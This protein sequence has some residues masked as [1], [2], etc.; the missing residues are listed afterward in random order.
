MA[1]GGLSLV[2]TDITRDKER[3]AALLM[4]KD[5]ADAANS[6]KSSFLANMSH[7]LRTPLNAIVGF[8]EAMTLGT[9]G[10]IGSPRYVEY[11]KDIHRSGRYLHELITDMLDVAK[12]E[13]GHQG[14]ARPTIDFLR[15]NEDGLPMVPPR[16]R[17]G[18]GAKQLHHAHT[19]REAAAD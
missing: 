1:D 7:E 19:H 16:A 9:F 12:I 15:E 17:T 18:G 3:E 6:A 2:I 5:V 11:A 8:S 13:A 14:L 10:P 4:A